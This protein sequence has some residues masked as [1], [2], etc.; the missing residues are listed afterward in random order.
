MRFSFERISPSLIRC[1]GGD[2]IDYD[3]LI[4]LLR[5]MSESLG[6]FADVRFCCDIR[7][8]RSTLDFRQQLRI[9]D[10]V[11]KH[12]R[13]FAGSRWAIIADSYLLRE[14]ADSGGFLVS[15]SNLPFE[16]AEFETPSS[17]KEWL[18]LSDVELSALDHP[19]EAS[20]PGEPQPALE[21]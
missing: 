16:H 19:A 6:Y 8:C 5:E 20:K 17:A 9:L 11:F 15:I 14:L 3:G 1:V 7:G 10:Y 13:R 12:T 4:G 18:H 2:I 21:V